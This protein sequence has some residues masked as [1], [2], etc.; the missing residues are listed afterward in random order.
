[1]SISFKA[2]A[3]EVSS[4][5]IDLLLSI[6]PLL[7]AAMV[8]E[9]RINDVSCNPTLHPRDEIALDNLFKSAEDVIS[10]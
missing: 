3:D 6:L 2:K 8:D 9:E 4:A 5:E 10:V 1:M 7:M